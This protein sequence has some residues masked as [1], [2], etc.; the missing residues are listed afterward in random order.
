VLRL[1][2]NNVVTK[3][4]VVASGEITLNWCMT[5]ITGL[6]QMFQPV[7][8][9][10]LQLNLWT[11]GCVCEVASGLTP[12]W[13]R[14]NRDLVSWKLNSAYLPVLALN[15]QS[16]KNVVLSFVYWHLSKESWLKDQDSGFRNRAIKHSLKTRQLILGYRGS[17]KMHKTIGTP[18]CTLIQPR[19]SV[20]L[21]GW[22]Y[23]SFD[24]DLF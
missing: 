4:L 11:E 16:L 2:A 19:V 21:M 17:P 5:S 12:R 10:R 8:R 9:F 24:C 14:H 23:H 18:P 22:P 6:P 13:G 7:G 3:S 1:C 20:W 15:R